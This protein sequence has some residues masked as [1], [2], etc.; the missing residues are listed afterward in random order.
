VSHRDRILTRV[1]SALADRAKS[2]HPG[3]FEGWRTPQSDAPPADRFETMFIAAGGEVVRVDGVEAA[4]EWSTSFVADYS[5]AVMGATVPAMLRPDIM[6]TSPDEA[7][8]GVSMARGAVGETGSLLLDA[9]DGR[10]TQLLA[11][12][13]VVF[14]HAEEI[15]ATLVDALDDMQEDLPSAIGLHSGPSK[16]ADIGQ[17]LVQGVHGP[18]RVIAVVIGPGAAG[19]PL[20]DE[21]E[22]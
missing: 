2:G 19:D 21:S 22:S 18:G 6:L 20:K 9:R 7:E 16:S 8:V 1:R 12:T 15:R 17:I 3:P 14:V 11:P 5:S 13:H 4:R 10:R